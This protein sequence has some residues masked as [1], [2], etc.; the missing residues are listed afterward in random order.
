MLSPNTTTSSL[1]ATASRAQQQPNEVGQVLAFA[2]G[3]QIILPR[4]VQ[5]PAALGT[6]NKQELPA[7]EKLVEQ[8]ANDFGK[9]IQDI[10]QQSTGE[11]EFAEAWEFAKKRSDERYRIL[12]GDQAFIQAI[13]R[14]LPLE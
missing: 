13:A 7:K 11:A 1:P 9:E 5:M 2:D 6:T 8:L 4:G 14:G 10:S 3:S 12:F